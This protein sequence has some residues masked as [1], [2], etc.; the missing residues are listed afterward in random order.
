M[1]GTGPV[2]TEGCKTLQ[3]E[4]AE[5]PGPAIG[6]DVLGGALTGP[7]IV[8]Q[9]RVVGARTEAVQRLQVGGEGGA[10]RLQGHQ[11]RHRRVHGGTQR[12]DGQEAEVGQDQ[13][14]GIGEDNGGQKLKV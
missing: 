1:G 10:V 11:P 8:R 9:K 3:V 12:R 13:P 4:G 5:V 6:Q 7:H 2:L 14:E